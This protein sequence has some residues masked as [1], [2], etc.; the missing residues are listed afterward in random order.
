MQHCG[1]L[2]QP[3]AHAGA[4]QLLVVAALG[5]VNDGL[6]ADLRGEQLHVEAALRRRG[7]RVE[8]RPV[9]HEVGA[10]DDDLLGRGVHEGVEQPEVVLALEARAARHD[11]RVDRALLHRAGHIVLAQNQLVGLAV[12]VGREQ[13]VDT[14]DDR[15]LEAHHEVFP[16]Q[17]PTDVA[18]LVVARVDEVLRSREA[19][20]SV[21]DEQLAV[22]AQV[23]AL[24][25]SAQRAHGQHVVP[26]RAHLREPPGRLAVADRA[27]GCD[28]VEQHAHVDSA[29]HGRL[30]RV[31]E[32]GGR[33]VERQDVELHV[34]RLSGFTDGIRHRLERLLVV[35]QQLGVVAADQRHRAEVAVEFDDRLEPVGPWWF[36]LDVLHALGAFEDVLVDLL[37]LA[38]ATPGQLRVADEQEQQ[39]AHVGD[40]EDRE[41]PGQGRLRPPVARNV[42]DREHA[43][44]E[45]RQHQQGRQRQVE[46]EH[47]GVGIVHGRSLLTPLMITCAQQL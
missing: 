43:D 20:L 17:A 23:G 1:R 37:L 31:E 13:R 30:E 18:L 16:V 40:K 45:V 39:D 8:H 28:V 32:G 3:D 14:G 2:V 33:V 4:Q 46:V 27:N 6:V 44:D 25:L 29:L 5:V 15:S 7:D 36:A 21:D 35:G 9:G 24:P 47:Y 42:D 38:A 11:L 34:H 12:P 10:R 19:D 41:Q 22:V 26:L